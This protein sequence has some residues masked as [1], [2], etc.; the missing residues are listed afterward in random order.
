MQVFAITFQKVIEFLAGYLNID[1]FWDI[2]RTLLDIGIVAFV[3]F[4]LIQILR[5]SRAWQILKG[6]IV[7]LIISVVSNF[8]GFTTISYIIGII[9]QVLPVLLVVL[10]QPEIRRALEG[11][12]KGQ[13]RFFLKGQAGSHG[14]S[15]IIDEVVTATV[16]MGKSRIGAL[17]IFERDTNL[18]EIIRTGTV[19]DAEVS[20]QLLQLIFVPNTPLHDGAVIIRDNKVYA[21]AC[22][23]PLSTNRTLSKELGT[24]HRAALG[25]TE[26]SDC[27]SVIVSEE[28]GGISIAEN[29]V[30]KQRLTEKELREFLYNTLVKTD[31][32]SLGRRFKFRKDGVK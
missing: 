5:D 25:V 26:N 32:D 29:G 19:V 8:L 18:G 3:F 24:R 16:N 28:T 13:L 14:T 7:I 23:L 30:L 12:G 6:V 9:L 11:M 27:V 21:A 22:F 4:K 2:V 31:N 17:I 1:S 10:F 20:S 15:K